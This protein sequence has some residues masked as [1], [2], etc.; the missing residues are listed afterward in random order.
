MG[1]GGT[2]IAPG[3]ARLIVTVCRFVAGLL[4]LLGVVALLRTAGQEGT[5]AL[6]VFTVHPLTA[7]IWTVLGLVGVAM[8]TEIAWA[9]RYLVGTGGILV[10]WAVL[11]LLLDGNPSDLFVRDTELIAFNGILGLLALVTALTD[12]PTRLIGT[13]E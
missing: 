12:A 4:L 7:L 5:T 11:C 10:G 9:R 13:T 1:G 2:S 3:R 8:G 6:M